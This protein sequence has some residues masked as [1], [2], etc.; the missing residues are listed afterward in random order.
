MSAAAALTYRVEERVGSALDVALYRTLVGISC[1]K[2]GYGVDASHVR[3][4]LRVLRTAAKPL[5][6]GEREIRS[7]FLLYEGGRRRSGR[8]VVVAFAVVCNPTRFHRLLSKR[9]SST[10]HLALLCGARAWR[11]VLALK[12]AYVDHGV[13]VTIEALPHVIAYYMNPTFGVVRMIDTEDSFRKSVTVQREHTRD[14]VQSRRVME[15]ID[16]IERGDKF[17]PEDERAFQRPGVR[18]LSRLVA[19]LVM[20]PVETPESATFAALCAPS[21]ARRGGRRP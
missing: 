15:M 1:I 12:A 19:H 16:E 4:R 2:D 13:G 8:E 3:D 14:K 20:V 11:L 18:D 7:I 5:Y 9:V 21:V 17:T 6:Y 10:V